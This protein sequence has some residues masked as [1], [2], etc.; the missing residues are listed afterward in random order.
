MRSSWRT[1]VVVAL[2]AIAGFEL[3]SLRTMTASAARDKT[4]GL[5]E[6]DRDCDRTLEQ[7]GVDGWLSYFAGDALLLPPGRNL[8]IGK[9]AIH[10]YLAERFSAPGSAYRWEPIDAYTS[11]DLGY[12]YGVW[13]GT[14]T[15]ADE[16]PEVTYGKYVTI[17]KKH[18]GA[19]IVALQMTNT[20]P[21]P[22][23]K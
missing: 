9:K 18:G 6:T 10:D 1:G 4:Q 17:W 11:G 7:N 20:N 21:P 8:V 2:A 5:I 13:K 16:K 12:T 3:G 14:Q 15:G 22:E 19:W 23:K